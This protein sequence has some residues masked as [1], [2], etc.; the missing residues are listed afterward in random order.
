MQKLI[1]GLIDEAA[2][3]AIEAQMVVFGT[4]YAGALRKTAHSGVYEMLTLGT[5]RDQKTPMAFRV[6]APAE[7]IS[8]LILQAEQ[9]KV[10][11]SS[12]LV[13]PGMRS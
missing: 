8:A 3:G 2:E 7:A 6:F 13:I 10:Q 12:G 9:P 4:P 5:Q 11:S 1:D